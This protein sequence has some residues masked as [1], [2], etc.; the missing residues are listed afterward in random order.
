MMVMHQ[1]YLLHD[2]TQF[3]HHEPLRQSRQ[4]VRAYV[5]VDTKFISVGKVS[6]TPKIDLLRLIYQIPPTG[7]SKGKFTQQPIDAISLIR[8]FV[9]SWYTSE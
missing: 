9:L 6:L 5:R 3:V 4:R 2:H 8:R 1:I 7:G